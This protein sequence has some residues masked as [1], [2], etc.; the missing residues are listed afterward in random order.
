M[1]K[2]FTC[3]IRIKLSVSDIF[4]NFYIVDDIDIQCQKRKIKFLFLLLNYIHLHYI[5]SF[6][7]RLRIFVVI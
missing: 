1:I 5:L 4:D 7:V 3:S 2:Q 6:F